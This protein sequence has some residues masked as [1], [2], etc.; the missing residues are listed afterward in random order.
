MNGVSLIVFFNDDDDTDN[1]DVYLLSTNDSNIALD[2]F[3]AANWNSV[4]PEF[5]SAGEPELLQLHVADGQ[6]ATDLA[7]ILNGL[8][9]VGQ[10]SNFE[11][12]SVPLS[13]S[14]T[15]PGLWDIKS[16]AIPGDVFGPNPNTLTLTG[17]GGGD[18]L[19][20][21]VMLVSVPSVT[22]S[23]MGVS[24]SRVARRRPHNRPSPSRGFRRASTGHSESTR[25]RASAASGSG[26]SASVR[27]ARNCSY[28][29]FASPSAPTPSCARPSQ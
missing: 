6:P 23:L 24:A 5:S 16:W 3:D 19:S 11:G 8:T 21:V 1:R 27:R 2:G 26:G 13:P 18:C 14:F 22:P 20:L 10:G 29:F 17:A 9:V 7:V 15:T 4:L 12:D 25:R 28:S